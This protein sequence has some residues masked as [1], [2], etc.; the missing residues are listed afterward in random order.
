MRKYI[1]NSIHFSIIFSAPR[2]LKFQQW[3]W[4]LLIYGRKNVSGTRKGVNQNTAV[5]CL[6]VSQLNVKMALCV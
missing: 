2:L 6:F 5:S 1:L 4:S 3:K